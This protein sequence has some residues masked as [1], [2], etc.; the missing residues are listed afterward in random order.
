MS[1]S[2][3]NL[4]GSLVLSLDLELAWGVRDRVGRED[5]YID[6]L[7]GARQAVPQLL[8]LFEEREISATWATVGF[9]FASTRAEL[10]AFA[11]RVR[12]VYAAVSLSPYEDEIGE[13]EESDPIHF[14]GSL[15]ERIQSTPRQEIATH[16]FSH[17]YCGERGQD[18]ASFRADLDA[19]LAIAARRGIEMRSIVFPRNQHNPAYDGILLEKGLTA[20]RGNP[21]SYAWRFADGEESRSVTKRGVRLLDTYLSVDGPGTTHWNEVLQPSGL[22]NVRASYPLRP[23]HPRW[24]SLDSL[25]LKRIRDSIRHAAREG[26]IFHLWWHPHNFGTHIEQNLV[27]LRQV[28]DQLDHCRRKDGMVSLTMA[29]VDEMAREGAGTGGPG[30]SFKGP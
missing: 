1:N 4:P 2:S 20:Y 23:Y 30:A 14:A 17:F 8:Q 28:L 19:A 12:P 9:L 13:G 18:E 6:N 29:E 26:E 27:F 24:R 25:R 22:A 7:L 10:L 15:I 3:L 5:P 11:P 16:T 21:P